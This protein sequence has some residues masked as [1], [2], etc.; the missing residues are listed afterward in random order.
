MITPDVNAKYQN[1]TSRSS[2][3]NLHLQASNLPSQAKLYYLSYTEIYPHGIDRS[4]PSRIKVCRFPKPFP[5]RETFEGVT[6]LNF[7]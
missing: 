6:L 1:Q 2:L 5:C 4:F 7:T 3:L